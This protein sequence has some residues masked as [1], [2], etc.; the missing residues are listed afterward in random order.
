MVSIEPATYRRRGPLPR[1]AGLE[2]AYHLSAMVE[3]GYCR[4]GVRNISPEGLSLVLNRRIEPGSVVSVDVYN[5]A[6]RYS[7]QVPLRVVY[8]LEHPGGDYI[9]GGAFARELSDDEV[10][11]LLSGAPSG[12][13]PWPI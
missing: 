10:Q 11:G 1:P 3:P 7:C 9:L 8:V 5:K 2:T 12:R 6:R 13:G 4:A